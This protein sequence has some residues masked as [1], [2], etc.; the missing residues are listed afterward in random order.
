M[1]TSLIIGG[2]TG[3]GLV[4]AKQLIKRGDE[5]YSASRTSSEDKNHIICDI[6]K[7]CSVL[8]QN[9]KKIDNLIFSHRYRGADWG[10][11]FEVTVKGVENV[12]QTLAPNFNKEGGSVVII[13]SNASSFVLKEQ[14]AEYHASRAAL[15]G[16]SNFYAVRFGKQGL[17]FNTILPSTLIKPENEDFFRK[18]N[19][20]KRMIEDI[21][22]LGRM[23]NSTDVANL[24]EFLC[25]DQSSFITGNSFFLDGGLSLIGQ[26]TIARER[27]DI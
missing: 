6:T 17:R 19:K 4:V 8:R 27:G 1:F 23:G 24:I 21:T 7:D 10:E 16:L 13:S 15:E 9:I 12:V 20:V 26:E 2:K 25:S 14:T 11:T 3:I 18:D 5:V 22:P